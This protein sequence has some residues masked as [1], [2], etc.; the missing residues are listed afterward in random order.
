[1]AVDHDSAE[2]DSGTGTSLGHDHTGP[3]G[4]HNCA[5]AFVHVDTII[6]PAPSLV[7]TADGT[8]LAP[9]FEVG[10]IIGTGFRYCSGWGLAIGS[11]AGV[12]PFAV[13]G[14]PAAAVQKAFITHLLTGVDQ[15]TPFDGVDVEELSA[16]SSALIIPTS[17]DD[18]VMAAIS[19]DGGSTNAVIAS[20]NLT[21][22]ANSAGPGI[23]FASRTG[24]ANHS[25][26]VTA[27]WIWTAAGNQ[28]FSA[29]A[30]NVR[31]AGGGG[32]PAPLPFI[33]IVGGQRFGY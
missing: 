14:L 4:T 28:P 23:G 18:L 25:S 32:A 8:P 17:L 21:Q 24:F 16:Q 30:F 13:S 19:V 9:L 6:D 5:V 2:V 26:F 7:V 27:D 29:G 10:V 1:M 20:T 33:T 3:V 31:A 22:P 11:L 15:V 12:I